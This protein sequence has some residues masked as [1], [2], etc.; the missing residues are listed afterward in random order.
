MGAGWLLVSSADNSDAE[1]GLIPLML[2]GFLLT[3]I[4]EFVLVV[5]YL[6]VWL[7]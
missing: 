2:G 1:A 7:L 6:G 3:A 5:I 4:I